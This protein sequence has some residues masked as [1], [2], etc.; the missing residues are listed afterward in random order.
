[1]PY[2]LIRFG[3]SRKHP[4]PRMFKRHDSIKSG[5][6]V[7]IIGGGNTC[8][9][10]TIIRSNYLIPEGVKFHDES[11]RAEAVDAAFVKRA[12]PAIDMSCDGHA[13][14]LDVTPV[15]GKTMRQMVA[16][17]RNHPLIEGFFMDRFARYQMTG[18]KGAASV[19]HR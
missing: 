11:V 15:C 12:I 9:N 14:I 4:Q 8:R 2:R 7:V 18:E 17:G 1:M 6:D 5:H 3:L 16:T 13:P 10:T 19:G